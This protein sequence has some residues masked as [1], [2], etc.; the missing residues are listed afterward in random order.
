MILVSVMIE[1][2]HVEEVTD[3][4][5]VARDI[6]IVAILYRIGQVIPAAIT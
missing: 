1:I 5:H 6:R 3:G 2:E 4:R